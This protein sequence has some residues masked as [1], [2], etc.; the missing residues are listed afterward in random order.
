MASTRELKSS[1]KE[2]KSL[3]P[4]AR[5]AS[6]NGAGVDTR[7]S[8]SALLIIYSGVVTDG[9]HTPKLQES[10]DNSVYNDVAA[11]DQ[12]GTLVDLTTS[13][14]Q[15]VAY[16]GNKRFVRAVITVTGGPSTG[17]VASAAVVLG[18]SH[19]TPTT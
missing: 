8:D 17:A 4:A 15:R 19:S 16:K 9:T 14:T 13:S 7:D 18:H 3:D 6:A 2:E 5:T 11:A 12:E 1:L 10:D